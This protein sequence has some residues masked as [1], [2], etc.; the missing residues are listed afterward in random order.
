MTASPRSR[1]LLAADVLLAVMACNF[2][3]KPGAQPGI[4]FFA[5]P[6]RIVIP[7]ALASGA[8][9]ETIDLVTDQTGAQWD[10]APAHLRLTLQDYALQTTFHVPQL[11]VYPAQQYAD[12][13]PS[14]AES[15]KRLQAIL[16]N[17]STTPTSD[18]LP[19]VP[20]LNAG[21]VLAT[22]QKVLHFSGGSGVRFITQYAQGVSPIN[23]SGLFY[24]FEGLSDDGRNY[25]VAILPVNLPFLAPDDNPGSTV[26]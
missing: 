3:R 20:F 15:I 7:A 18:S 9:A 1:L 24:H 10:V 26:P 4:P 2:I 19:R 6:I 13:N 22:Q 17:P 25:I 16:A 12:L 11:F 23:N 8:S 5:A 14:A 21:Q